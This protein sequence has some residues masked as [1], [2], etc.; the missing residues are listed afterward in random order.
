MK[1]S[2][3]VGLLLAVCGVIAHAQAVVDGFSLDQINFAAVHSGNVP[4][5]EYGHAGFAV[6]QVPGQVQYVQVVA[7]LAGSAAAPAW[8]VRNVPAIAGIPTETTGVDLTLLGVQRGTCITGTKI[9]YTIAVTDTVINAAPNYTG[10]I[11]AFVGQRTDNAEGESG[12]GPISRGVL[13]AVATTAAPL[14]PARSATA[15]SPAATG[16][17]G[18]LVIARPGMGNVVQ[19]TNECGPG[20]VTNS[21]HWLQSVGSLWLSGDSPAQTLGKVK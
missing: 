2:F 9:A 1:R 15:A 7:Q 14:P 11:S 3:L 6:R 5:S 4:C 10:S 21:M 19:N 16:D 12:P 13:S 18:T 8:I 17:L 20:A